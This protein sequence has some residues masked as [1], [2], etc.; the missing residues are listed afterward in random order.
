MELSCRADTDTLYV[1]LSARP[2]VDAAEISDGVVADFD[3]EGRLVGLWIEQA[4]SR[5]DVH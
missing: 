3:A 1:E 4:S 5:V 2:G